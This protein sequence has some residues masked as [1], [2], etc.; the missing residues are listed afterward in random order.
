[1]GNFLIGLLGAL[2]DCVTSLIYLQAWRS[3]DLLG[4]TT[5]KNLMLAML[6]EVFVVLAAGVYGGSAARADQSTTRRLLTFIAVT[7]VLLLFVAGFALAFSDSWWP[8]YAFLWL[9]GSRCLLLWLHP[10]QPR[11]NAFRSTM[12]CLGSL[13]AFIL[14]AIITTY[15]PWPELGVTPEFVASMQLSGEGVWIRSPQTVLVFGVLY[16][17]LIAAL[18]FKLGRSRR[19][20]PTSAG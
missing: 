3:P 12:L 15:I 4:P 5:V 7:L 14:G 16:F 17:A 8:V 1:M 10:G 11:D 19:A 2:P 18:K 9:F 13:G 20:L 6:L